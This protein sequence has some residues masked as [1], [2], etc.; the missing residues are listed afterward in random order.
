MIAE[1]VMRRKSCA[2]LAFVY[3]LLLADC[4]APKPPPPPPPV[5]EIWPTA[6]WPGATPES[7]GLDSNALTAA[8]E[9]I[10]AHRLPVHSILIERNGHIVLDASF[11][12]FS[13]DE[14]HDLASVTK[15]VISTLVGIAQRDHRI[16]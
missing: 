14:T 11:F 2:V 6:A 15:S 13:S 10:R 1:V 8:I 5:A 12:P 9:T 7:Q 16:G 3:G 4:S